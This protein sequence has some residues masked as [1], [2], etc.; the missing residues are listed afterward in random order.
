MGHGEHSVT[1]GA[2]LGG[3]A[4]ARRTVCACFVAWSVSCGS[5]PSLANPDAHANRG[6]RYPEPRAP[7]VALT[8]RCVPH[9]RPSPSPPVLPPLSIRLS[10]C[11]VRHIQGLVWV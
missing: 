9:A 1:F 6:T 3:Q 4:A 7:V 5:S 8:A 2:R 10:V 11:A